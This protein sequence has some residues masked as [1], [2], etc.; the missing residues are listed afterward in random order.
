[1]LFDHRVD[2]APGML[3]LE[4]ARQAACAVGGGPRP[5]SGCGRT[6]C[7]TSNSTPRPS[8]WPVPRSP[9]A[10]AGAGY[11]SRSSSTASGSSP[12]R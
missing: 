9:R 6:S 10:P 11:P 1:M 2:H 8:S 7:G 4:A 3:L 12:P 5:S